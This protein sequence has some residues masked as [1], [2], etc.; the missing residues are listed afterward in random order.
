MNE[1]MQPLEQHQQQ[2]WWEAVNSE[3]VYEQGQVNKMSACQHGVGT[4]TTTGSYTPNYDP[5]QELQCI[6]P[7][8]CGYPIKS[9]SPS[10]DLA[11]QY[12]TSSYCQTAPEYGNYPVIAAYAPCQ[13][14]R[15][16]NYAYCY[17]YYGE[18]ACPLINMV[19][20]EDFM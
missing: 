3:F 1:I 11:E 6:N 19:D 18:P 17:G 20:M 9:Y 2:A 8:T 12:A 4:A 10:D 14:P 13:G 15:P 7:D 16:W 5:Y